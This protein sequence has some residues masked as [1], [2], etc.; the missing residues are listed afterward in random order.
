MPFVRISLLK[1]RSEDE[2]RAISDSVYRAMVEA[3]E[4][5]PNDCFQVIE[6][7][8]PHEL[9]YDRHYL[10]G[11]RSERF[12]LLQISAG[13]LRSAETKKAFYRRV[14]ERLADRPGIAPRDVMIIIQ[15]TQPEDWSLGDGIATLVENPS[16]IRRR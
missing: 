12:V 16:A 10:G 5:P 11:P 3:F 2:L 4:V 13:W 14:T 1:G 7:L 6:S 15:T 8:D 9:V